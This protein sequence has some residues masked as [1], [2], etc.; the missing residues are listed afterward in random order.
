MNKSKILDE[1]AEEIEKCDECKE[2]TSGLPVPG[3]GNPNARI[4]FIGMAPGREESKT[5]RPFVGRSGRYLTKLLDAIGI[6]RE[7]VYITSPVKYFPGQRLLKSSE[8]EHSKVH[9]SKQI[10]TIQPELMVLLGDTA[11]KAVLGKGIKI[12]ENHGKTIRKDRDYFVTLHP[13]AGLRFEKFREII[14]NDFKK[15]GKLVKNYQ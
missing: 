6:N 14:K 11:V 8:I 3:E 2:N 7:D 12:S 10:Q 9:L 4:M 5:G 1:I 13:S 15:L